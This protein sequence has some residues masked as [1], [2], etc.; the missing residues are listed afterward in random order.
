[1]KM[2]DMIRTCKAVAAVI[3]LLLASGALST[4]KVA[5]GESK[6]AE[7]SVSAIQRQMEALFVDGKDV[8]G[9]KRIDHP[10]F[11][12]GKQI[13]RYINGYGE[14]PLSYNMELCGTAEYADGKT[15]GKAKLD[16]YHLKTSPNAFGLYSFE[17]SPDAEFLIDLG[18]QG[19]FKQ[20]S[21]AFWKGT[22]YVRLDAIDKADKERLVALMR[23]VASKITAPSAL[24]KDLHYI[25]FG[26]THNLI[27]NSVKFFHQEVAL[28]AIHFVGGKNV[29]GLGKDTDGLWA[30]CEID[31][32]HHP[33]LGGQ[34]Y[35]LFLIRYPGAGR[36]DKAYEGY[37]QHLSAMGY[38]VRTV[39]AAAPCFIATKHDVKS[40][41]VFRQGDFVGGIW[42]ATT[43]VLAGMAM[44]M[45]LRTLPQS[46]DEEREPKGESEKGG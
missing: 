44:K 25:L 26:A 36:A 9:W 43:A 22:Y 24:P 39:Q 10:E 21:V 11:Y 6:R 40:V 32:Q 2:K 41:A 34:R 38:Q 12:P 37:R 18:Q 35:Q 30:Q 42:E 15:G 27:E 1:M 19:W 3:G 16:I 23:A 5:A 45:L 29:L 8:A 17:R 46:K 4:G 14:I 31:K 7:V 20:G 33:E 13:F 28:N